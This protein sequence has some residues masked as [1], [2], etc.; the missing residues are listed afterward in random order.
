MESE[1]E[2]MLMFDGHEFKRVEARY[3]KEGDKTDWFISRE[4][5]ERRFTV[6][7]GI[8]SVSATGS[9]AEASVYGKA[10]LWPA[11][12]VPCY[13]SDEFI[14]LNLCSIADGKAEFPHTEYFFR[15]AGE[16]A[17]ARICDGWLLPVLAI[18]AKLLDPASNMWSAQRASNPTAVLRSSRRIITSRRSIL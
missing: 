6:E 16:Y 14:A 3:R 11:V 15:Q 9:V 5:V 17:T 8:P 10:D 1:A 2:V 12:G 18:D 7:K 13:Y 4:G